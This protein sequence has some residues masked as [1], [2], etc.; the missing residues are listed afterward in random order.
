MASIYLVIA[1]YALGGGMISDYERRAS[2]SI[3]WPFVVKYLAWPVSLCVIAT[4]RQ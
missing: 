3:G 2:R 4:W 1:W